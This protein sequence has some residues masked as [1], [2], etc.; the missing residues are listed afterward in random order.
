MVSQIV[1]QIELLI[2]LSRKD[3]HVIN[4]K[5]K[6]ETM[7][8]PTTQQTTVDQGLGEAEIEESERSEPPMNQSNSTDT[9]EETSKETVEEDHLMVH[10][11]DNQE[12]GA[13][14][15][16]VI[17]S[18][19]VHTRKNTIHFTA[20]APDEISNSSEDRLDDHQLPSQTEAISESVSVNSDFKKMDDRDIQHKVDTIV[21]I[22]RRRRRRRRRRKRRRRRRRR[23]KEK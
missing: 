23:R 3:N 6:E 21:Q 22:Q 9:A 11:I 13:Q 5:W 18:R 2:K 7:E 12:V 14:V 8:N 1:S 10:L 15:P 19:V 16:L 4:L 17:D 20:L